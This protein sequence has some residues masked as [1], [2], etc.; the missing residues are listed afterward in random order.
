MSNARD[1]TNFT[2]KPLRVMLKTQSI[3]LQNLYKLTWHPR[4]RLPR[5]QLKHHIN[6]LALALIINKII[7]ILKYLNL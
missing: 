3:L 1:I 5:Q 6:I 2:T 4:W 7:K